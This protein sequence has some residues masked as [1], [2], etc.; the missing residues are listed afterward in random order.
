MHDQM[1]EYQDCISRLMRQSEDD[2]IEKI[3]SQDHKCEENNLVI[4][5]TP[6]NKL[7]LWQEG[8]GFSQ[9]IKMCPYCGFKTEKV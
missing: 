2:L 3:Q 5:I 8:K 1:K 6:S 9:E 7:K 4:F